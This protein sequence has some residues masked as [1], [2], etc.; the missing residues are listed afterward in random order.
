MKKRIEA[1]EKRR[2]EEALNA[3][4]DDAANTVIMPKYKK[5]E[6]LKVDRE[7]DAPPKTMFIGLGWDEDATT[8]RRHYRQ[9]FDDELENVTEIFPQKSPFNS[10]DLHHGL[11]KG[12]NDTP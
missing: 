7:Y 4:G 11:A 1:D 10:Y 9:F 2:D 3:K 6:R 12:S 5:D 8:Q